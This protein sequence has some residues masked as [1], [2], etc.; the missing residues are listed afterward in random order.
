MENIFQDF[1]KISAKT[2]NLISKI[3]NEINNINNIYDS[4]I[5]DITNSFNLKHEKLIKQEKDIKEKLENEV[6]KIK[7]NLENDL[8]QIKSLN[9]ICNRIKKGFESY[10]K[11][12]SDN[13]M[14][15]LNYLNKANFVKKEMDIYFLKLMKSINFS[16]NQDKDD[17]IINEYYFNGISIPCNIKF[18]DITLSSVKIIW[19]NVYENIK[20]KYIE[21]SKNIKYILSQKDSNDNYQKIYEGNNNYF[22]LINISLNETYEFKICS[23]YEDL[24]SPWSEPKKLNLGEINNL[25]FIERL[26][27]K[28]GLVLYNCNIINDEQIIMTQSNAIQYGPYRQYKQGKYI[29]IYNGEN[30]LKADIDVIDNHFKDKFNFKII[31][32][33]EY[34]I[35][36]EV[37]IKV[38]LVSGIEFRTFNNKN[39]F[40]LIKYIDV[41]K[42]NDN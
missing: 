30:L 3:E 35:Y 38:K 19:D 40:V 16:F 2:I 41:F 11:N 39:S 21:E 27:A 13:L 34:N 1:N 36:Y 14:I 15:K 8:S 18:E 10:N 17:I 9:S 42:F 29:I 37:E 26:T 31:N 28:N 25:S 6:T 23:I 33:S 32:K 12:K 20:N 7:E 5:L 24:I 22:E 4:T